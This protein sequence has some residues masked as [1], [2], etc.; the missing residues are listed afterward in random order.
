MTASPSP[1]LCPKCRKPMSL[2]LTDQNPIRKQP[3]PIFHRVMLVASDRRCLDARIVVW[4]CDAEQ[5]TLVAGIRGEPSGEERPLSLQQGKKQ[6]SQCLVVE[7]VALLW[8]A[9]TERR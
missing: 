1:K 2:A 5:H 9:A 7:Y 8:P 4:A 3:E 6:A